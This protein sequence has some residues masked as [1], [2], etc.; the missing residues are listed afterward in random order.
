M[1]VPTASER[2]LMNTHPQQTD[3]FL[4]VYEPNLAMICQVSGSYNVA[5]QTL[6]YT[7]VVSGTYAN[8][9]DYRFQVALVGTA[10]NSED[11]GRTWVRSATNNTLRFVESDHINWSNGLW[12]TV[13]E[14]TE[15]IPVFPRIIQNPADETDVIFYKIWDI[16]YDDQN[17]ILGT[18]PCMGSNYAGF[19]E[20]G[21]HNVYWTASGTS[22]LLGDALTYL[23]EFE[24]GTPTGSTAHTP[25]N[26]SYATPG[27][28]RTT[29]N[30]TSASGRVDQSTRYVSIYDRPGK[31]S[32]TP[33]LNFEMSEF[34]GSRDSIGYSAR[35]RVRDSVPV[36]K[37]RDGALI[38]IFKDDYY[39]DTMSSVNNNQLG[40]SKIFFSGYIETGSIQYNY[41]DSWVEFSIIS[42]TKIMEM[43]ECFSVSVESKN[44]PATWY[45]LIDM[46]VRRAVYHYLAWHSTVLQCCDFIMPDAERNIQYFDADRTSLYDAINSVIDG[47]LKGKVVS[48]RLGT[49]WAEKEYT[50]LPSARTAIPAALSITK[51]DW[52]GDPIIDERQYNEVSFIEIGGISFNPAANTFGAYLA[53]APGVSPAYHG[54]VERIQGLALVD[55]AD[56]NTLA[57]NLYANLNARYPSAEFRLRGNFANLDVNRERMDV[58]VLPEDTPRGTTFTNE[59][60]SVRSVSWSWDAKTKVLLPTVNLAQIVAGFDGETVIIPA[61]PPEGGG[62]EPGEPGGVWTVPPIIIP[63]L[64]IPV[65]ISTGTTADISG[66]YA[67]TLYNATSYPYGGI[68]EDGLFI[69]GD[70]GLSDGYY[71][72]MGMYQS[73][74]NRILIRRAGLYFV[75]LS[76]AASWSVVADADASL[77]CDVY[78]VRSGGD[79]QF[80][81][82]KM[83]RN[84]ADDE[85][86]V[87]QSTGATSF[88]APCYAGDQIQLHFYEQHP[89]TIAVNFEITVLRL[90]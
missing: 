73:D 84:F 3:L 82:V 31:G 26:V 36:T 11:V 67:T 60:F 19:L 23:W 27:H 88:V 58:T 24:G 41:R 34:G 87:Y 55:Q 25:G 10:P 4:S 52:I 17:S 15:I 29:L 33:I 64:P 62:N 63:P 35:I 77:D 50:V 80:G 13:L 69:W 71:D 83:A 65:P 28:Y 46:T 47:S 9:D 7:N 5:D 30:I 49:I 72:P 43:C 1:S 12:I 48:D 42:P 2:Q 22:N 37:L 53:D 56:L 61:E 57:G 79:I 66:M 45:E 86:W 32:R 39:G 6:A 40:R 8:I 75:M 18:F 76:L 16:A 89:G 54:S 85:T 90:T 51:N 59:P 44:T 74:S 14:Y 38:V 21:S 70:S 68:D 20:N 81:N 78:I